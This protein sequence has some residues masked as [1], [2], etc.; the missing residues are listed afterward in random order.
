MRRYL[1]VSMLIVMGLLFQSA[2]A[3]PT[4]HGGSHAEEAEM[5]TRI[6]FRSTSDWQA[7]K[8]RFT[9]LLRQFDHACPKDE[10]QKPSHSELL[11]NIHAV[12]GKAGLSEEESLLALS[13]NLYTLTTNLQGILIK[14]SAPIITCKDLWA[15]YLALR[16]DYHPPASIIDYFTESFAAL[17]GA[18]A[19]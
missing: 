2:A 7:V 18:P 14:H 13:N 17:Y 15:Q 9:F 10:E 12:L 5:M 4:E 16:L 11:A 19:E 8:R 6:E 3:G 1:G